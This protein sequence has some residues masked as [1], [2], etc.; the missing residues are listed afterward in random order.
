M[1]RRWGVIRIILLITVVVLGCSPQAKLTEGSEPKASMQEKKSTEEK[2]SIEEKKS[3]EPLQGITFRA[4]VLDPEKGLLVAPDEDS[5]EFRSSDR[6]AVNIDHAELVGSDG[7]LVTGEQ[8]KFGDIVLI[9]YN[10]TIAESYPAQITAFK[11][12]VI[13]HDELTDGYLKLI[14]DI[15]QEDEG[16]NGDI[17]M[18]ALDTTDWVEANQVRKS[19]IFEKVKNIY[20]YE[21]MEGTYDELV[22]QGL[23]DQEQLYFPKGILIKISNMQYHAEKHTI[24]CALSKWRSGLGAIGSDAVTALLHNG[25]WKVTKESMWIS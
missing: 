22:E 4:E 3:M 9:S 16:L 2:R 15:F 25:E 24:T 18:I 20:G 5:N 6:M 1:K 12:E 17:E 10:G 11:V 19:L 14:D 7:T 8:L 23:I 13:G 21:V